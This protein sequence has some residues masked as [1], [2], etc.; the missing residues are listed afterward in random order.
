LP[1]KPAEATEATECKY[2]CEGEETR[3]KAAEIIRSLVDAIVLTPENGDL[4][5]DLKGDL[6]G[7]LAIATGGKSRVPVG[8]GL[9]TES[10]FELVADT[11]TDS[12]CARAT[13]S[14]A[15][16]I[17]SPLRDSSIAQP[18]NKPPARYSPPIASLFAKSAIPL[19]P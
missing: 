18:V 6:A 11:A 1:W 17:I 16:V 5:V 3:I 4:R 13:H 7:I 12:D 14:A 19:F 8:N 2:F 10:Q 9:E 15:V